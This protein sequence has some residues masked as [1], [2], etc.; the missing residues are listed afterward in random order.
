MG[1]DSLAR[2]ILPSDHDFIRSE[3]FNWAQNLKHV[4]RNVTKHNPFIIFKINDRLYSS[5]PL[6]QHEQEEGEWKPENDLR[7]L[8]KC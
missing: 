4:Q 3:A 5:L 1:H 2:A 6:V 7:R 8:F